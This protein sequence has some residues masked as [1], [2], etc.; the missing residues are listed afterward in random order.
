MDSYS[1]K[2]YA[3]KSKADNSQEARRRHGDSVTYRTYPLKQGSSFSG[4][5][6]ERKQA[7]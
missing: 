6:L 3:S 7:Q 5:A 2:P 4:L 1:I